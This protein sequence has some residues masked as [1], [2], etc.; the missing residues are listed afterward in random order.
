MSLYS[1]QATSTADLFTSTLTDVCRIWGLDVVRELEWAD[2]AIRTPGSQVK[3][4]GNVGSCL[5]YY[6]FLERTTQFFM[7]NNI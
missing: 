6:F 7:E 4:H 5:I 2:W 1:K 3:L